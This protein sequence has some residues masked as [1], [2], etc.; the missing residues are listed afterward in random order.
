[1]KFPL[2]KLIF[3]HKSGCW[4]QG[5]SKSCR[6][7]VLTPTPHSPL[8]RVGRGL[9]LVLVWGAGERGNCFAS[10]DPGRRSLRSLALILCGPYRAKSLCPYGIPTH[11]VFSEKMWDMI[12]LAKAGR[13]L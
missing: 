8:P 5:V 3:T 2:G 7:V 6:G 12:S 13:Q 11:P 10:V 4:T 1:M 9:P